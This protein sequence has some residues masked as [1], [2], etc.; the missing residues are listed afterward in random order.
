M[1][2]RIKGI[3][4]EIGG[5]TTGLDKALKGVNS[6]I[7]STQSQLRDVNRLL[8]LDPSNAKLLAQKQQLLQKEISET[9]NK[10]NALKEADKQA[11][12][13]LENGELGQDKYT[14]LEARGLV[15]SYQTDRKKRLV[16]R[17]I[18][19][20]LER[21]SFSAIVG[22][23]GSGK[24]TLLYLLSGLEHPDEGLVKL[25]GTEIQNLNDAAMSRLR[26]RKTGF[27][28]Q[29]FNLISSMTVR[30]NIGFPLEL[31]KM[32]RKEE[33]EIIQELAERLQI[34]K[35]LD[36]YPYQLSGGEQQ[37]VAIARA[38]AIRPAL[39]FADEPTGNLDSATGAA[40][41]SLLRSICRDYG[42]TILM[43]THD[44]DLAA[45]CERQIVIADGRVA[46]PV[47]DAGVC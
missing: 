10:L 47:H 29:S 46:A 1:A 16:I 6:T 21:G 4:V 32:K 3:T 17:G 15:K 43:V 35:L 5:D 31:G 33:N 45:S 24:S 20:S 44:R 22:K 11:K 42:T 40:V 38:A 2:N 36:A 13:Q 18:D 7:K 14:I 41:V 37:R 9:S 34:E 28:F 27:I 19:L 23:S 8:K 39:I 25:D 30:R 26:R 12:V